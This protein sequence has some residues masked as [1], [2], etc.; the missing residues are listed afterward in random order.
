MSMKESRKGMRLAPLRL[1]PPVPVSDHPAGAARG[2]LVGVAEGARRSSVG[3]LEILTGRGIAGRH[4]GIVAGHDG[5]DSGA[6]C[7]D[8]LTEA[9][10]NRDIGRGGQS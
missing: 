6:V 2:R 10:V 3:P 7:P 9:E 8:G 1:V 4:I 5:N